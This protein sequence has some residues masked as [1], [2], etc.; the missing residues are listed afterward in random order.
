FDN[1]GDATAG[2]WFLANAIGET[3]TAQGGG[4]RFSGTHTD[5]DIL[6]VSDFTIGGSVSTVKVFRWTRPANADPSLSDDAVGTLVAAPTPP[7]STFAAVNNVPV[8]TPWPFLNK[9]KETLPAHGEFLEEGVNLSAL[10]LGS[11]FSSF[12][13]ETRSSQS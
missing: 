6:L 2:F 11:C 9:S 13:A 1:S 7:N 3:T 5:G 4:F 12:L 8:S 10:G